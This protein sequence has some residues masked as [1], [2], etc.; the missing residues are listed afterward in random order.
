MK[1]SSDNSPKPTCSKC[2]QILKFASLK[3]L[4]ERQ[5]YGLDTSKIG[6]DRK[7]PDSSV[8]CI[9]EVDS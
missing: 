6:L 9:S 1:G 3:I 4:H 5:C 8:K 2:G 7:S